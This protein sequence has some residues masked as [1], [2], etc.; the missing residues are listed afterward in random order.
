MPPAPARTAPAAAPATVPPIALPSA[1]AASEDEQP[2]PHQW[3]RS[4]W[5]LWRNR[6]S[7]P[8]L[9][10]GG[11][12]GGS[13]AGFRA[14]RFLGD[15]RGPIPLSLYG[16]LSAALEEPA[17]PETAFGIATHPLS[18]GIP[19]MI[20]LERR[21]PLDNDGRN[22]FALVTASGLNP[23]RIG[24]GVTAEGY[25]Q[26]GI[27]GFRRGDGFV[28]GRFSLTAALDRREGASAGISLSGGTQPGVSRLD[29]G[30]VF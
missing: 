3:R 7:S 29:L 2:R 5:L 11:Q 30:P 1:T 14:D 12:L 17:A 8:A 20:G 23:A 18:G 13:Q 25:A 9:A 19:L 21:I 27:V 16:R 22:A 10:N 15:G 4:V 6:A 28:D 26:A 24:A